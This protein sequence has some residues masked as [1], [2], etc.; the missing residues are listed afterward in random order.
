MVIP[1]SSIKRI[2]NW[3]SI[4]FIGILAV[5]VGLLSILP[6]ILTWHNSVESGTNFVL[7]Q[8]NVYRDEFFQYLPRAREVFDGHFPPGGVYAG[9]SSLSPLNPLPPLVFSLF[10]RLFDGNINV[11]YL[12]AQFFFGSLIFLLF[13]ILGLVLF[14]SKY[15]ATFFSLVGVLTQIPQLIFRYYD[16]DYLSVLFKK[17]IPIVRTP[18]DKMYFSRIDDPMLT[19]PFLL[20]ALIALYFFWIKPNYKISILAGFFCGLLAYVYLHYFLF[21]ALFMG[22]VLLFSLFLKNY[23]IKFKL[24]LVL[25]FVYFLTLVPYFLNYLN[26]SS[27]SS[28]VD[29]SQRLGK[30]FSVSLAWTYLKSS[31]GF[32]LIIN[33]FIYIVLL[34]LVYFFYLRGTNDNRKKKGFFFLGLVLTMFFVW[35][36]PMLMGFGFALAHFNKPISLVMFVILFDLIKVFYEYTNFK[37]PK[38]GRLL[39][40]LSITAS[41]SLLA[42]HAINVTLFLNPEENQKKSYDFPYGV[43][44]SWWWI[45]F[46]LLGEPKM[47]SDS[48]ITSLYLSSYTSARPY[49]ATGFI[50]TISNSDLENRFLISNKLF[51]VSDSVL[52]LRLDEKSPYD[53]STQK[54]IKDTGINFDKSMWY[55]A[56]GAWPLNFYKER[57]ITLKNYE[58]MKVDWSQTKSNFVYYGPWEK[59]FSQ[60][61]FSN[62]SN[63][64]LIYKNPSAEIYAIKGDTL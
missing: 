59:Q 63:L 30:E 58:N 51:S 54:C 6:P 13:F 55:L 37:I 3:V 62:D 16:R 25:G 14:K 10:L 50:S 39:V 19:I 33:Y 11:A 34:L 8:Q 18:L 17:F 22:I 40:I 36:I 29:Y 60:T 53:C 45:N 49:T 28:S 21:T 64:E 23:K 7:A 61:N 38:L 15:F 24:C 1:L 44:S 47:V 2:N 46:N 42:K 26:F 5:V 52:N 4:V 43:T 27:F 20:V 32:T 35:H 12:S 41:T 9:E 57:D 31:N 48:L 56:G